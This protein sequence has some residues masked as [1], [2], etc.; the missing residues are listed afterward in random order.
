MSG[1]IVVIAEKPDLAKA[2]AE[3]LGGGS[4]QDGYIDCGRHYVTWVFGHMLELEAPET[5]WTMAELPISFIPWS[6]KPSPDKMKQLRIIRDLLKPAK[7]IIH[8]GDPDDEGQ[9]PEL[10]R[11]EPLPDG[12]QCSEW[13]QGRP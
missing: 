8:A 3:G 1:E 13:A 12:Q 4:R 10:H 7:S 2:I 11:P 6:K 5:P 9:E